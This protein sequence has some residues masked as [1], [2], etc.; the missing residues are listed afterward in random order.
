M[1]GNLNLPYLR[2]IAAL[3]VC[4]IYCLSLAKYVAMRL[5]WR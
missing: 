4:D 5:R 3:Y 2:Y 1:L